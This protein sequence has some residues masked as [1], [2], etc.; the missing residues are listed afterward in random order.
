MQAQYYIRNL[1]KVKIKQNDDSSWDM[2][3]RG[4]KARFFVEEE[5]GEKRTL[6][7]TTAKHLGHSALP[8]KTRAGRDMICDVLIKIKVW[9]PNSARCVSRS[10]FC[11]LAS[12]HS[13]NCSM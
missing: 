3:Q 9:S 7:L 2:G 8:V 4:E 6:L 12:V 1:A 10:Y 5:T 13:T 11:L